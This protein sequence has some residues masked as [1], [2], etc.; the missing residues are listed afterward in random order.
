MATL[1]R[2]GRITTLD[3]A[4]PEVPALAVQ[5]GRVAY[6]GSEDGA[7]AALAGGTF[8]T[9][10]LGGRRVFPGFIDAHAH[11]AH[12]S[13]EHA[14]LRLKPLSSLAA[15]LEAVR[16]EAAHVPA[17]SWIR[18]SGYNHLTLPE[19]RH[20]TRRDLDAAAPHHP[21]VLTRTCGHIAAVNTEALRRA[22]LS[23]REPDPPGGRFDRDSDGTLNGVLYD[24]AMAAIQSA[25]APD[26]ARLAAWM[27]EGSRTWAAAGITAFH[28]A[29]GPPGYFLALGRA[30]ADGLIAQRVDA[31]VWNGLGVDQLDRFL[32]AHIGTGFHRGR[33]YI[34][35]AKIMMDGSS[36]GPTAATRTPYAVDPGFSGILYRDLSELKD[37]MA[38]AARSGFQLTTHAV[39]DRAVEISA[40]AIAEVGIRERRN[41]IEHCA[42]CPQDLQRLMAGAAITPVAQPGFLYEFGDGYV[43]SYGLDR[44]GH[45]FPLKSW[46]DAGLRVAGSSDSPVTDFRPLSGIAA[47]VSRRTAGGQ[48]LAPSERISF[49]DAL[50]LYT[51]NPAWLSFAEG[52]LGRL[53]PGYRANLVAVMEDVAAMAEADEIRECPVVLTAIEDEI[54]HGEDLI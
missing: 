42:M 48:V 2:N 34:G 15:I 25:S 1:Y 43:E 21:V 27:A 11:L 46:L 36:S 12:F 16:E 44:G 23:L 53:A 7:R 37:V 24:Q 26:E 40:Q 50:G 32:D 5:D 54:V 3:F 41:R 14:N 8:R 33:F 4:A 18:G 51:T 10:D 29:G 17:G 45:M 49:A 35:A 38:R 28:D 20:P 31:M 9:I 30:C 47:A 6:R 19:R 52:E 22:G 39:G 13:I